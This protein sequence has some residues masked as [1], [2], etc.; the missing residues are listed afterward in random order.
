M[1]RLKAKFY[2]NKLKTKKYFK[3]LKY[4]SKFDKKFVL[5]NFGLFLGDKTIFRFF[6]VFEII[7][8]IKS[9][10]GDII[11]FG[12]WNGNNLLTIKKIIEYLKINKTII[13]YDHFKGMPFSTNGNNFSGDKK[14]LEYFIKFFKFEKIKIIDD[15]FNNINRYQKNIKKISFAY[16]DCDLYNETLKILKFIDNKISKGGIIAFDEAYRDNKKGEAKALKE[17]YKTRKKK[18]KLVKRLK[19]YQPDIL[20]IRN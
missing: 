7:K 12:V 6:S 18:Y 19:F 1:V 14:I 3:I 13:G 8:K 2:N 15:D 16:V 9:I 11:E 17:F 4:S 20:L 5:Q 10:N